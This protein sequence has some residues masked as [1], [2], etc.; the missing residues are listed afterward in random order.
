MEDE[1]LKVREIPI[2]SIIDPE[3]AIRTRADEEQLHQLANSIRDIGLVHP[4][5][6]RPR[7]DKFEVVAGHRRLVACRILG[8]AT[9]PCIVREIDDASSDSVKLHENLFRE[10][11]NPIDQARLIKRVRDAEGLTIGELAKKLNVSYGYVQ[12]R[13]AMLD[14]D[15]R[16]VKAV[17]EGRISAGS[18]YW[19]A[20]ITDPLVRL[21]YL[22]V[23]I[24]QGIS[25][26]LARDWYRRWEAK[27]LPTPPTKIEPETGEVEKREEYFTKPCLLCGKPIKLGD[28]EVVFVHRDCLEKFL[29]EVAHVQP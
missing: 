13:L 12:G 28:E 16:I 26:D 24:R 22:D 6:V 20:K 9:V 25:Q 1:T 21:H 23:A 29:K 5:L 15:P 4:L 10:D 11:V 17:E 7:G 14:W 3:F 19:F 2:D 8:L 27:G 18:A